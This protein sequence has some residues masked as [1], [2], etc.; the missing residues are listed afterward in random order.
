MP[1][2]AVMSL[3][4]AASG[5]AQTGELLDK[6]DEE[7]TLVF[8]DALFVKLIFKV[9]PFT[10]KVNPVNLPSGYGRRAGGRHRTGVPVA[11]CTSAWRRQFCR[12]ADDYSAPLGSICPIRLFGRSILSCFKWH[13]SFDLGYGI[14]S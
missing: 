1:L 8:G 5:V 9:L 4:D 7:L 13:S 11:G 2:A 6:E 3:F 10:F 14:W 12:G